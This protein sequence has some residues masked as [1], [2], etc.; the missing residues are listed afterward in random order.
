MR[1]IFLASC[2]LQAIKQK[3]IKQNINLSFHYTKFN[4]FTKIKRQ[5]KQINKRKPY[6]I[7]K[8]AAKHPY[9]QSLFMRLSGID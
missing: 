9:T 3:E 6:I 4:Y 7:S 2:Y 8:N 1:K 5:Q